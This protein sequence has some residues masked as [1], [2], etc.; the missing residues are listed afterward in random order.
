MKTSGGEVLARVDLRKSEEISRPWIEREDAWIT[1]GSGPSLE[2]AVRTATRDMVAL[3]GSKLALT[4]EDAFMLVCATGD[5]R[6]GQSS[7]IKGVNMTARVVMPK[8]PK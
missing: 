2:D 6:I 7:F 4:K 8:L 5:V 1:Y 3:L